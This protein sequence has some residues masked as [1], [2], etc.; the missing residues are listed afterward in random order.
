[1]LCLAVGVG[2]GVS[3]RNWLEAEGEAGS[4]P[5]TVVQMQQIPVALEPH[6]LKLLK[7]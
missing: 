1:M 3:L 5:V 4:L 6:I 2:A 7:T